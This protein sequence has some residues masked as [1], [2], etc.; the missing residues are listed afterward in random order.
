MAENQNPVFTDNDS[1]S[2][3]GTV[4]NPLSVNGSS[5]S[6]SIPQ[7]FYALNSDTPIVVLGDGTPLVLFD[8]DFTTPIFKLNSVGIWAV[9]FEFDAGAADG[10]LQI[11]FNFGSTS[12]VYTE[13]FK[14]G[15]K[16][17]VTLSQVTDGGSNVELDVNVTLV[18]TSGED[19]AIGGTQ[20]NLSAFYFSGF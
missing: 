14:S 19:G 10:S 1:V 17:I 8:E 2:G 16:R 20:A 11:T 4:D 13:T 3:D 18:Y 5:P 12:F 7:G 9:S 15:E 6:L